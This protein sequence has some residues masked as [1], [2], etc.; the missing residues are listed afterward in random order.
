MKLDVSSLQQVWEKIYSEAENICMDLMT[1]SRCVPIEWRPLRARPAAIARGSIPTYMGHCDIYPSVQ[2]ASLWNLWRCYRLMILKI[3]IICIEFR[4]QNLLSTDYMATISTGHGKYEVHQEFQELIDS[5]C[6]S[7]PYHLG[8]RQTVAAMSDVIDKSLCFPSYHD[9]DRTDSKL[10]E[11]IQNGEF[12]SLQEHINHV[13]VQGPW[14]ILSTLTSVL[15]LFSERVSIDSDDRASG[16]T[17]A[18]RT[19]QLN[20]IQDQVVRI[21]RLQNFETVHAGSGASGIVTDTTRFYFSEQNCPPRPDK[22]TQQ[23]LDGLVSGIRE[24]LRWS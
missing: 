4:S 10:P 14:H 11:H 12:M 22:W 8:N 1:W 15:D 2:V 16:L 23:G 13:I 21:A 19:G 7:V 24:G 6:Y 18:I 5:I 20:W 3:M 17:Y 9:F